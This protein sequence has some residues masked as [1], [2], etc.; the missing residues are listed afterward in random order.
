MFKNVEILKKSE[1][2][3]LNF[4]QIDSKEFVEEVKL[5]PLGVDEI[6]NYTSYAPI[7]ITSG[8]QSEF[9]LFPGIT[10]KTTIF[11]K[12]SCTNT[13]NYIKSYPF[14][15]LKVKDKNDELIDVIGIDKNDKFV[16][17]NKTN[18]IFNSSEELEE[19][20]KNKIN[21]LKT[22]HKK[23]ELSRIIMYNLKE[24]DL[25]Q[26]QSFKIRV[27]EKDESILTDYYIVNRE[28]LL[29]LDDE[30]LSTWSR[31]GWISIIDAHLNSLKNFEKLVNNL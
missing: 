10:D 29:K 9:A 4:D 13:P 15:M 3:S 28:K 11:H 7:I 2:K 14:L 17:E 21:N 27:N 1:F 23:R 18:K 6:Y 30:T 5:I 16:G 24:K 22:F 12:N 31:K 19:L 25:L 8:K 20:S 26:K